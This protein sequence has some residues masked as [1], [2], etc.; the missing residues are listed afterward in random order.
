[1]ALASTGA[2]A[3]EVKDLDFELPAGLDLDPES[4]YRCSITELAEGA[5]S[6]ASAVGFAQIRTSTETVLAP[7]YNV[8]PSPGE[9]ATLGFK[10]KGA[11]V[12]APV[13][14]RAGDYGMTVSIDN[15]PD[16]G[17]KTLKLTLWGAPAESGHDEQRGSCLTG[18]ETGC[19]GGPDW[20]FVTLPTA[21]AQAAETTALAESWGAESSSR[22]DT[23]PRLTGCEALSLRSAIEV[24]PVVPL[25]DEPSG[26]A[27][28]LRLAQGE[29]LA[30]ELAPAQLQQAVFVLPRGVSFSPSSLNGVSGCSEAGARTSAPRS[31]QRVRT[32]PRSA[33]PNSIPRYST[34]VLVNLSR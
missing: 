26:Y 6:N 16:W 21:C 7:V 17:V 28:A 3:G 32:L 24:A 13:S 1:M 14:M 5:C 9:L 27:L 8:A 23:L 25:L 33:R 18:P 30:D 4:T 15:I 29:E 31:R 34:T 20:P 2:P 10:L 22:V 19:A 12:R 11:L